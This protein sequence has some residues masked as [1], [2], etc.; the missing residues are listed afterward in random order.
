MVNMPTTTDEYRNR[1]EV[2]EYGCMFIRL[3]H[4]HLKMFSTAEQGFLAPHARY[5]LGKGVMKLYTLDED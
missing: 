5:I 2:L 1:M 3:R 4:Q